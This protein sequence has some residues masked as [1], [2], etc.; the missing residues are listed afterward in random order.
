MTTLNQLPSAHYGEVDFV[1][2][3]KSIWKQRGFLFVSAFIFAVGAAVYAYLTT[4]VYFV[5]S[6]LRPAA[7]NELDALNRTGLYN[8][9]PLEALLEVA[10][11]LNSYEVRFGFF[12]S[13]PALVAYYQKSGLTVEQSFDRFNRDALRLVLPD[14]KK[15]EALSQKIELQ[16]T[17]PQGVDGVAIVNGLVEYA[18]NQERAEIEADMEV[19]VRNRIK[20]LE[21]NLAASRAV[22]QVDKSSRIAR[23]R[24]S[25]SLKRAQLED[26]LKALRAQL[27]TRRA[28]RIAELSEAIQI[29]ASLG[30]KRPTTPSA[31][32]GSEGGAAVNVLR[33]EVNNQATPLYFMGSDALEAEKKALQ[34]RVSD[35]FA[36]PR[37]AQLNKELQLLRSNR[38]VQV[39][40]R[41][42]DEDNFLKDTEV[43]NKEMVRLKSLGI[44][45]ARLRLAV[46]DRQAVEPAAPIKPKKLLIVMLGLLLGAVAGILIVSI[47]H[48]MARSHPVFHSEVA[49]VGSIDKPGTA[50]VMLST[51]V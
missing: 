27:K 31:L 16:L 45:L 44:D 1:A 25:D 32:G 36:E 38:E 23:L 21:G 33:T 28:D 2:L 42:Q 26:E 34:R 18:V 49:R 9:T 22:Y 24:E 3:A 35:D 51:K 15:P 4:P 30:I 40:E 12:K 20:E 13:N 47:R 6:V 14:P 48:L 43:M 41:R 5:N 11:A 7:I 39:L 50:A 8:L 17:Y 10:G 37:I 29:A 19:I 46:V